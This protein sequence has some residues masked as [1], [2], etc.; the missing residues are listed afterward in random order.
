MTTPRDPVLNELAWDLV[1][2]TQLA[3]EELGIH[4]VE[5]AS[6]ARLFDFGVETGGSLAAGLTL[7]EVCTSG[8]AEISLTRGAISG[9]GWP[10]VVVSTDAPID[11][12]L[13]S[14]YAGWPIQVGGYFGMGSGPMRAA[15]AHEDLFQTL[16]FRE[17]AERV[18][19]VIESRSLPD[20]AV[21]EQIAHDCGVDPSQVAILVAPTASLA[22]SMQV[23]A[24]SIETALH[25]LMELKFDVMRIKSAIGTAPFA[26]VA[27]DDLRGIGR[28]NDAILYGASVTLWVTGN[29]QSIV[30]IGSQ[31]PSSASSM[32]GE[33]FLSIFERA[34]RD[35]YAVDRMLFSPAEVVFQNMETGSVHHFGGTNHDILRRS[36]GL[37]STHL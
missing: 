20:D 13:F 33:P 16:D 7:A 18:V 21:I 8:L 27:A 17:D 19:G 9:I 15:A 6:G 28:T 34:G 3:A 35:F 29:D 30:D 10:E 37:R 14:Q 23:V 22:G 12:C 2:D 1:E 24:R 11:A 36:F 25:K 26:P 32:Y 5:T 4:L 31:V